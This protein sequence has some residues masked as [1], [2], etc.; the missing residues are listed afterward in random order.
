[1]QI[2]CPAPSSGFA[3]D[4]EKYRL[5]DGIDRSAVKLPDENNLQSAE[6]P[7]WANV[8]ARPLPSPISPAH[9]PERC[10]G[11]EQPIWV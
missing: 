10:G 4:A 8:S 5:H 6:Q 3:Y 2:P 1:V 9:Y 11:R 7:P